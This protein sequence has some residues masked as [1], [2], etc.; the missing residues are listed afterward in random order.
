M[1]KIKT[2]PICITF[3]FNPRLNVIRRLCYDEIILKK[4]EFLC[5]LSKTSS[6]IKIEGSNLWPTYID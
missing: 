6:F 5:S 4:G 2:T 3:L 1:L